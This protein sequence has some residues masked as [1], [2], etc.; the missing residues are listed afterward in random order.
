[1]KQSKANE[2]KKI[3]AWLSRRRGAKSENTI[4]AAAAAAAAVHRFSTLARL[5]PLL[6]QDWLKLIFNTTTKK[7]RIM[8]RTRE[9]V[10]Q[11]FLRTSFQTEKKERKKAVDEAYTLTLL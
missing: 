7:K 8:T 2:R 6:Q 11:T 10:K 9:G 5:S 4:A 3:A 1:M